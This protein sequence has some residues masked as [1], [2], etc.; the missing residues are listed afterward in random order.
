[1]SS[2]VEHHLQIEGRKPLTLVEPPGAGV[3][4]RE[5]DGDRG[6]AA[7]EGPVPARLHQGRADSASPLLAKDRQRLDL[8]DHITGIPGRGPRPGGDHRVAD[9][10]VTAL[11]EEEHRLAIALEPTLV[12]AAPLSPGVLERAHVRYALGDSSVVVVERPPER[13]DVVDP[14]RPGLN[15]ADVAHALGLAVP[16]V[17]VARA[18][19]HHVVAPALG[20]DTDL[21]A[22][23]IDGDGGQIGGRDNEHLHVVRTA[24]GELVRSVR[25]GGKADEV[26]GAELLL[27]VRVAHAERSVEHQQ[28]FL[29]G[30]VVVRA[31][32]VARREL[33]QRPGHRLAVDRR[34]DPHVAGAVALGVVLVV[35]ELG[36]ED[37]DSFMPPR[38]FTRCPLGH[39]DPGHRLDHEI[40]EAAGDDDHQRGAH[41]LEHRGDLNEPER[42]GEQRK[43]EKRLK[44]QHRPVARA[45]HAPG[46]GG[47]EQSDRPGGD[48]ARLGAADRDV[49]GR[50]EDRRDPED[51]GDDGRDHGANRHDHRTLALLQRF[52]LLPRLPVSLLGACR[53]VL[54]PLGRARLALHPLG[55]LSVAPRHQRTPASAARASWSARATDS[56]S[57]A[58]RIARTT[59]TRV[60]PA[61]ATS[62]T[63]PVS[64]PPIANHGSVAARAA[65]STSSTPAAGR[66]SFV[67]VSQTG[68]T[69][70]WS[71]RSGPWAALA[72][73]TCS[74]VWVDCPINASGPAA[75]RASATGMSSWPTWAPS[76]PHS[77]TRS[78]RSLRMKR[79]PCSA[80]TRRNGS[81]SEMSSSAQR[82][83]FSRSWTISAPPRIAAW[84][85]GVGSAPF[86]RPSQTK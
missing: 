32:A 7:L 26:A 13:L 33:V 34:G 2:Q 16:V 6:G 51:D 14:I 1:M 60:A 63:L 45:P 3:R 28:P 78:G 30:L 80:A 29:V 37:V 5:A 67:G 41:G 8:G 64:I 52:E 24:I 54:T 25:S 42:R 79:P 39:L 47:Q 44:A 53:H 62:P 9:R 12:L 4:V 18:P 75:S 69:L 49:A 61:A 31:V 56:G 73:S 84:S 66:P 81:A 59:T 11:G 58:S 55:T 72:A 86:G 70:T 19:D 20:E 85:S 38:L 68:P 48:G 35:L 74:T 82:G 23:R 15:D 46:H 76:A 65:Y 40:E 77:A 57:A 17:H 22:G 10:S 71:G 27:A 50:G 43:G 36:P 21:V 83:A